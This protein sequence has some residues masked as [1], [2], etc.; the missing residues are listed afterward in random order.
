M[1]SDA[2]TPGGDADVEAVFRR[3][4]HMHEG[5]REIRAVFARAFV[6]FFPQHA[7]VLDVGCGDGTFVQVLGEAG[8]AAS[9]IDSDPVKVDEARAARLDVTCRD[10]RELAAQNEKYGGVMASHIIEHLEPRTAVKF[11]FDVRAVL[12]TGGRFVIVTPNVGHPPV[13]EN[14]WLDLTHVRPYPAALLQSML[15]ACGFAVVNYGTVGPMLD[16]FLVA[17]RTD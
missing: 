13:I 8:I 9:G 12:R 10:L 4:S 3:V 15:L 5:S 7:P 6:Q 14:F 16:T 1:T 17:E 2:A 11:M